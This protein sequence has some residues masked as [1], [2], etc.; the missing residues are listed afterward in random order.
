MT[1]FPVHLQIEDGDLIYAQGFS[2]FLGVLSEFFFLSLED[3]L[4]SVK[5]AFGVKVIPVCLYVGS[6]VADCDVNDEVGA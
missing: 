5:A 4:V 6:D 3:S 2:P 1:E